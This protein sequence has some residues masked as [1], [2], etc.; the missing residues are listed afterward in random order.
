MI[1]NQIKFIRNFKSKLHVFL[2]ESVLSSKSQLLTHSLRKQLNESV[3]LSN[4]LRQ[5][6]NFDLLE[7]VVLLKKG[8]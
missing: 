5:L 4:I 3:Y 8:M 6:A 2:S 7:G 1:S